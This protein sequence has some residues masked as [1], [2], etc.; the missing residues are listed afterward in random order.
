MDPWRSLTM[1]AEKA[2]A[3]GA[4]PLTRAAMAAA[5]EFAADL[6]RQL[7]EL[8][9]IVVKPEA[10]VSGRLDTIGRFL[11][12]H[13]LSVVSSFDVDLDAARSHALWSYPWVKATSDRI[14]LHILMSEREPS[15]CLL[16]RRDEPGG[17]TPL[18]VWIA[19][20]KGSSNARLRTAGQLRTE[21]GMSNRMISFVHC[22]D[23]PADLL[24]DM[25]VLGGA[26]AVE[27]LAAPRARIEAGRWTSGPPS[28]GINLELSSLLE[29]LTPWGRGQMRARLAARRE[30]NE[31]VNLARALRDVRTW[32][33]RGKWVEYALAAELIPY[34]LPGVT[35]EF[36][37]LTVDQLADLW[38]D[39]SV[40]KRTLT[41]R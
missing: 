22:P 31:M 27:R 18:T 20:R 13:S 15:R 37:R 9:L 3:Y 11:T 30:R 24:R 25:Y 4:D 41:G 39:S 40:E 23:E 36:D 26:A 29:E 6:P 28:N 19:E 10:L 2:D 5:G 35:A 14:R 1:L 34:D 38:R 7:W 33:A 17:G 16:V 21:L 12:A 32:G 8:A